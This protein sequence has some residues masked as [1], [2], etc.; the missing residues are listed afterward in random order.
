MPTLTIDGRTVEVPAGTNLIEAGLKVGVQIPHYCY[1]PRLSVVGQ[2]RLCMV[3]IEGMGK[4]QAACS[5]Q[6]MKAGSR[7]HSWACC[8]T[9]RLSSSPLWS[10]SSQAIICQP[11]SGLPPNACQRSCSRRVILPGKDTGGW[12]SYFTV[13]T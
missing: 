7:P 6:V 2:C 11:A 4:L 12:S 9:M 8:S 5:T 10:M 3:E 13:G 1:H